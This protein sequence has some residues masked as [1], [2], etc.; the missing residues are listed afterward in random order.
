VA[1]AALENATATAMTDIEYHLR[2]R[3]AR[4]ADDDG[5]AS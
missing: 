5:K 3:A 4:L 1:N 2:Q